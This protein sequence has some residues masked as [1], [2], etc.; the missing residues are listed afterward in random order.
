MG[1]NANGTIARVLAFAESDRDVEDI[2]AL[3]QQKG[4]D[5]NSLIIIAMSPSAQREATTRALDVDVGVASTFDSERLEACRK[6]AVDW[7][8][9]LIK[10]HNDGFLE[11]ALHANLNRLQQILGY[12]LCCCAI[13]DSV[14]AAHPQTRLLL[15]PPS[16]DPFVPVGPPPA[17]DPL[18][19]SILRATLWD[20][21]TKRPAVFTWIFRRATE[22]ARLTTRCLRRI[23]GTIRRGHFHGPRVE[24]HSTKDGS[25]GTSTTFLGSKG[26]QQRAVYVL[27]DFGRTFDIVR[28]AAD[29]KNKDLVYIGASP[30]QAEYLAQ[31]AARRVKCVA[32]GLSGEWTVFRKSYA[33]ASALALIERRFAN[34]ARLP[35]SRSGGTGVTQLTT[36]VFHT[37]VW[38]TES[39]AR[40]W[41]SFNTIYKECDLRA[42]G[43][44][45]VD[46]SD[47]R[48]SLLTAK[49]AGIYT[50]SWPHSYCLYERLSDPYIA[51]TVL[52]HGEIEDT[53]ARL[54]GVEKTR[55]VRCG[56]KVSAGGSRVQKKS[57]SIAVVLA[58]ETG[59]HSMPDEWV[60]RTVGIVLGS[61][62]EETLNTT[63]KL[64]PMHPCLD[65]WAEIAARHGAT[66]DASPWPDSR[67]AELNGAVFIG[68]PGS[69][70]IAVAEAADVPAVVVPWSKQDEDFFGRY[71]FCIRDPGKAVQTVIAA[72]GG[73]AT[74]TTLL[75]SLARF[76]ED[77]VGTHRHPETVLTA[78][79][80]GIAR[81]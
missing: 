21:T 25:A 57:D 23:L 77:C 37:R 19:S 78:S 76:H 81:E 40:H 35:Q 48:V 10:G 49:R 16:P 6:N 52:V 45:D 27:G 32:N 72:A 61:L 22:A 66:L 33:L 58:S 36:L 55:L 51:E 54:I 24:W 30:E 50:I 7:A 80:W 3:A 56:R 42:I 18:R 15:L 20:R 1:G 60:D 75:E 12:V 17:N 67:F 9:E 63:L 73:D 13:I 2:C 11:I 26:A 53:F 38:E 69:S 68:H 74:H 8:K 71:A 64:H 28:F 5:H 34:D 41:L 79:L 14:L 29:P 39:L 4:I 47:S 31:A 65:R 44:S 43:A 62:R 59:W 46:T 70:L